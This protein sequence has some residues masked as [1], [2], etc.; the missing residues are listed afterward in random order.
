[1]IK[2]PALRIAAIEDCDP[3]FLDQLQADLETFGRMTPYGHLIKDF[4]I[5]GSYAMRC[6]T[7][8][9]DLDINIATG[10]DLKESLQLTEDNKDV[11]A[12]ANQFIRAL[13]VK[14]G[15][16]VSPARKYP[17]AKNNPKIMCFS[18]RER[19]TYGT[20]S[21]INPH[22]DV[23]VV[24]EDGL[25]RSFNPSTDIPEMYDPWASTL[26]QW[27]EKYGEKLLEF[28]ETPETAWMKP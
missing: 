12:V 15:L 17:F 21:R 25:T 19:K 5:D 8:M 27:R 3:A 11:Q 18:L 4:E 13:S 6:A 23:G 26:D 16:M 7:L 22:L 20:V 10:E 9:S 14:Y 24:G 2:H 1:M 28:G